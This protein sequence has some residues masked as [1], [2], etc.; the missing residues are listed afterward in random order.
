MNILCSLVVRTAKKIIYL[1]P[2]YVYD[3]Y[4]IYAILINVFVDRNL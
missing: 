2:T 1:L 4:I 3:V